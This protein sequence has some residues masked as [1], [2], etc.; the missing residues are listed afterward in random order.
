M[1]HVRSQGREDIRV[2]REDTRVDVREG[3]CQKCDK[4]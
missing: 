2:G 1:D 3:L 4:D